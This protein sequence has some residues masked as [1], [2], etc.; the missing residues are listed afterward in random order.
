MLVSRRFE[1]EKPKFEQR[2]SQVELVLWQRGAFSERFLLVSWE[3]FPLLPPLQ[4]AKNQAESV[5]SI[6]K[7][8]LWSGNAACVW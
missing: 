6:D 3:C 7:Y 1:Q 2:K 5:S 8:L 4:R